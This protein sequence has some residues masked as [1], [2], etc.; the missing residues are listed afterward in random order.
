M[1]EFGIIDRYFNWHI[2]S[3]DLSVSIGDDA[4][5]INI[6]TG[7]QLVT[8]IDTLI[9]GV[10]FPET[11]SAHAIAYKS[12]AVNLSDIAAMGAVPKWFTLAITLPDFNPDW[13]KAFSTGL[14]V[15]AEQSGCYLI[16]GDTTRGPLSISIQ[17]LG[18]VE[19]ETALLRSQAQ[20]GD[21]IY[22][23]GTLGDAAVGL[24][25]Y[26]DS[27]ILDNELAAYCIKRL[28]YPT[29]RLQL[30]KIIRDT[31]HACI[32]VS[33]GLLQDLSHIL[34]ASG[35]G[36]T[37]DLTN[38]PLSEPL[39]TFDRTDALN[40]A[41]TGGDDYELLFTL[42]EKLESRLMSDASSEL[43]SCIGVINNKVGYISDTN[44]HLLTKKGYNHFS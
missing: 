31:A 13:L 16:G 38:I 15:L 40:Y 28:N 12:L 23:S 32:D 11:T 35:V 30:G 29:P 19:K 5:V 41:L 2:Y 1:D 24:K 26:Q 14:K 39:K 6:P 20:A 17:V 9:S 8:C 42:P 36:A 22:V 27:V 25:C 7:K 10:H 4:A 3:D 37:L 33:D 21:R 44:G 34:E 18:L 43:I